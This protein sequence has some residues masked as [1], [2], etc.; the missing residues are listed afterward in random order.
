MFQKNWNPWPIFIGMAVA[1]TALPRFFRQIIWW[2][3][4]MLGNYA[5]KEKLEME[6]HRFAPPPGEIFFGDPYF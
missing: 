2:R 4:F 1:I 5:F 6:I 3:G